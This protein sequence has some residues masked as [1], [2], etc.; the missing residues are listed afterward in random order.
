M[1]QWVTHVADTNSEWEFKQQRESLMRKIADACIS[2]DRLQSKIIDKSKGSRE[3][4]HDQ[5]QYSVHFEAL[6]ALQARLRNLEED[7]AF[8]MSMERERLLDALTR[9]SCADNSS[10]VRKAASKALANMY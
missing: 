1:R 4:T 6:E 9:L 2:V 5:L 8:E 3:T 7:Y 10:S